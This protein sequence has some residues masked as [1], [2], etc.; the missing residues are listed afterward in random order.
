VDNYYVP[1]EPTTEF[2]KVIV[3]WLVRVQPTNGHVSRWIIAQGA[4]PSRWAKP[5]SRGALIGHVDRACQA[6]GLLRLSPRD[7]Y[8]DAV[9]CM[10][11]RLADE[12]DRERRR[13]I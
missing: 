5:S 13:Y 12:W 8:G 3:E 2:Q 1:N 11:S 10:S 7:Q 4:F 9:F 6:L